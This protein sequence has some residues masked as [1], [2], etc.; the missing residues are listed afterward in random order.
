MVCCA[1]RVSEDG[2]SVSLWATNSGG[3]NIEVLP[4]SASV[5][6][7]FRPGRLPKG[8]LLLCDRYELPP[9]LGGSSRPFLFLRG[10]SVVH[11]IQTPG[12]NHQMV[13]GQRRYGWYP[14]EWGVSLATSRN[15]LR[16]NATLATGGAHLSV[17]SESTTISTLVRQC[18]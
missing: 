15:I 9:S 7:S 11:G 12:N 4:V 6:Q 18:I 2:T 3:R 8:R 14:L 10:V 1:Y 5:H 13:K 17:E 16:Y